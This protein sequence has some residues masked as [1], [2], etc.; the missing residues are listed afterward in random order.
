MDFL[1]AGESCILHQT[2]MLKNSKEL[3][4]MAPATPTKEYLVP[5]NEKGKT[6]RDYQRISVV[7]KSYPSISTKM[8]RF[9]ISPCYL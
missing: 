3:L 4:E 9:T 1:G 2:V 5:K 8:K 7:Y 6:R